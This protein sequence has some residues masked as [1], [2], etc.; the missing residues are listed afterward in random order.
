MMIRDCDECGAPLDSLTWTQVC[1]ICPSCHHHLSL[2]PVVAAPEILILESRSLDRRFDAMLRRAPL[3]RCDYDLAHFSVVWRA[4]ELLGSHSVGLAAFRAKILS[5]RG[6][7][8]SEIAQP[9]VLSALRHSENV[10]AAHLLSEKEPALVQHFWLS[11]ADRGSLRGAERE[12][13]GKLRDIAESLSVPVDASAAI[14]HQLTMSFAN[15]HGSNE[16]PRAA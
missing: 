2:N 14:S 15:W 10:V 8:G 9:T 6:I 11:V 7:L 12:V 13:L 5:L 16:T 4:A 3:R 1:P